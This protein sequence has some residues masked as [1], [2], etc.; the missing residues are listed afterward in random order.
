LA[1]H[2]KKLMGN[3]WGRESNQAWLGDLAR[4]FIA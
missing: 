4:S 1:V 3:K 2:E